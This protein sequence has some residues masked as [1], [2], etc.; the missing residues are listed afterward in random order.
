MQQPKQVIVV[1]KDL[2][3]RKGKLA[4]QVAHASL[5]AIFDYAQIS[6]Q[7]GMISFKIK[8]SGPVAQWLYNGAFTK[9]VV[10]VETE[11]DLDLIYASILELGQEIREPIPCSLI[12]DSGK[13]EFNGVPTK[14]CVAVGPFHS[15]IV[16]RI[17]GHLPLL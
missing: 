14:T 17:T 3:M 15:D 10:Y 5:K 8:A 9:I 1:R 4:A 2:Q 13:T 6:P 12:I 11:K 7:E 16:N